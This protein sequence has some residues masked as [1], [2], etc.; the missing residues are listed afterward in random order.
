MWS[1]KKKK[2]FFFLSEDVIILTYHFSSVNEELCNKKNLNKRQRSYIH[3]PDPPSPP[4][5]THTH[6]HPYS[7]VVSQV[8]EREDFFYFYFSSLF[9]KHKHLKTNPPHSASSALLIQGW[10]S[11]HNPPTYKSAAQLAA[12]TIST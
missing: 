9:T 8:R 1:K 4:T 6:T 7:K 2:I 12:P 11:N 3:T 10:E 5:R